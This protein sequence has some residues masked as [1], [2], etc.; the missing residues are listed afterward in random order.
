VNGSARG[1]SG[2]A[3]TVFAVIVAACS[4]EV[5]N[6]APPAVQTVQDLVVEPK[7][8][9]ALVRR[10]TVSAGA[11]LRLGFAVPGVIAALHV[12]AG[13][14]VRAGQLLA[15][16]G[17]GA[18]SAGLEAART[19]RA[20]MADD[21]STTQRLVNSGSLPAADVNQAR[22]AFAMT[23]AQEAQAAQLIS[24]MRL[25][26]P[27]DGTVFQRLAER[28]EAIGPGVPVLLLDQANPVV[29]LGVSERDRPRVLV[30]EHVMIAVDDQQSL[31][32]AVTSVGTAPEADGLYAVEVAA[33]PGINAAALRPG[34]LVDVRFE[35][36]SPP[37]QLRIPI[38]A[39]VHQQDQTFVCGL[40]GEAGKLRIARRAI[41][42]DRVEG[43]E[44]VVRAGLDPGSRIVAEGAQFL[45]DGQAVRL[46]HEGT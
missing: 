27:V 19:N 36:P 22:V 23:Q 35:E 42:I 29:K 14:V 11:R 26:A 4:R 17:H 31:N 8:A 5:P 16:L 45:E 38:D 34:A 1:V 3:A 46:I 40:V 21:L 37:T 15:T 30:G 13:D 43:S 7:V 9:P 39:V 28:G 41:V 10:G 44:A 24:D 25:T 32:A 12:R 18:A 6:V 20:R 33:G 2:L